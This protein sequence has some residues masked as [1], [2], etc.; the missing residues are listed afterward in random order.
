[1]PLTFPFVLRAGSGWDIYRS[2][3]ITIS[4]SQIKNQDDCVSFKPNATNVLVKN[5]ICDGSHG[6]SVGAANPYLRTELKP[7][8][9]RS[10]VLVNVCS[11]LAF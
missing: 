2:D 8:P 6:I 4:N 1:V 7:L 11:V 5:L 3:M 9:D 10:E